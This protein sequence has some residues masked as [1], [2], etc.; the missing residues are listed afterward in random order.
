MFETCDRFV[1]VRNPY[2][3]PAVLLADWKYWTEHEPELDQ[4]CEENHAHRQGMTVEMS[5]EAL[6]QFALRWS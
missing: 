6:M 3:Q 2:H 1:I 4:W 5:N